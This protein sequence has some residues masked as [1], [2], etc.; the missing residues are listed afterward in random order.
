MGN[1]SKVISGVTIGM[2]VGDEYSHLCVL[3]GTGEVEEESRIRTTP[4]AMKRAFKN[5]PTSRSSTVSSGVCR[6]NATR[7]SVGSDLT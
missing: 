1:S 2:D 3:D 4:D 6:R 5:M 7:D